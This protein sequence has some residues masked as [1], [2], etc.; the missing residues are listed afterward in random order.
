[1]DARPGAA[2]AQVPMPACAAS[3]RSDHIE[4][5]QRGDRTGVE[6][7]TVKAIERPDAHLSHVEGEIVHVHAHELSALDHVEPAPEPERVT[8]CLVF[9]VDRKST[10]LN[11][12]HGYISYAVFCLKKKNI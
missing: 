8:D 1:M 2:G 5:R 10:R 4:R 12:S 7:V 9:A 3:E 6:G 11:S